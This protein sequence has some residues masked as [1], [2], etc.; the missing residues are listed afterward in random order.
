MSTE[1]TIQT[2]RFQC[3]HVFTDGRRCGSPALRTQNFCYFHHTSRAPIQ[4]APTRKRRQSTFQ[5]PNPADLSERSGIQHTIGLILRRIATNEVDPRRAGLLLYGL[6]IASLNL[7][8]SKPPTGSAD[9]VDDITID[10]PAPPSPPKPPSSNPK[11]GSSPPSPSSSR[12]S[13]KK[14]KPKTTKNR[15]AGR[16]LLEL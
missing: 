2:P 3:R 4:D 16:I 9:I 10:P 12:S 14:K 5:L 1:I 6:Q 7:G 15:A 13:T 8:K 11:N